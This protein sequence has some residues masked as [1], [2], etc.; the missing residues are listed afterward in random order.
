M[1]YV[2]MS[3]AQLSYSSKTILVEKR[4]KT[5]CGFVGL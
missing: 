4:C 1:F 2:T 3:S 5:L